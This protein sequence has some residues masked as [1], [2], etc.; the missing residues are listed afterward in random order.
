MSQPRAPVL[1]LAIGNPSRGDDAIGPALAEWLRTCLSRQ[2]PRNAVEV[3]EDFQLQLEHALD[4]SGRAKVLFIDAGDHTEPG[5]SLY[6]VGPAEQ[7]GLSSHALEPAAV[8]QVCQQIG[9]TLP[10]EA[11][12]LC[13]RGEAFELGAP[14]TA[15]AQERM[16]QAC[17]VLQQLLF[18]RKEMAWQITANGSSVPAGPCPVPLP[19]SRGGRNSA[20]CNGEIGGWPRK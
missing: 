15:S 20:G 14:L 10:A 17:H 1:V 12:V 2:Q 18:D 4:L 13:V 8:L 6:P 11:Y 7:P 19:D 16:Q 5:V 3:V 9:E